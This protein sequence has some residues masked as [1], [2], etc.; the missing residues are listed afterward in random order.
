VFP[1]GRID[2]NSHGLIILTNDGR[3]T[4]RLLSPKYDHEKEYIVRVNEKLAS[5]FVSRIANGVAIEGYRTKPCVA[6]RINDFVFKVVLTEG[7]KHQIRR[8][9]AA[10]GYTI[11]DLKRVRVGNIR[12][13]A[14]KI[15]DYRPIE[16]K[17]LEK[18]LKGL[19]L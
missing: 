19:G 16:G 11:A 7:K 4:E 15:G 3:I 12:L 8:M 9:A 5:N 6:E 10:L 2:K 14:L 13:G 17:E 1:I 18:F